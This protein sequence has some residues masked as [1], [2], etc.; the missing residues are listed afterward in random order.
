M[1]R[2]AHLSQ[3]TLFLITESGD[4]PEHLADALPEIWAD[5][6]SPGDGIPII[7]IKKI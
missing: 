4:G 5:G 2:A 6:N 7:F 3:P 1:H